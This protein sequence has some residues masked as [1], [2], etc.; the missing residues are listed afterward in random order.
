MVVDS[1]FVVGGG[2]AWFGCIGY[3][4]FY[5]FSDWRI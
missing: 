3:S 1:G 4:A 5:G 2:R